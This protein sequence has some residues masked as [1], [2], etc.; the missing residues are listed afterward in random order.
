M[1]R[2]IGDLAPRDRAL[3]E[4]SY[5][6]GMSSESVGQ[7]MGMAAGTVR[8]RLAAIREKLRKRMEACDGRT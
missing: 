7:A 4:L 5:A 2:A 1:I 8:W 6:D 3:I